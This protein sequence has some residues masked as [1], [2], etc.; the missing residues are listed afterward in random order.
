MRTS[1][2]KR[3]LALWVVCVATGVGAQGYPGGPVRLV[4]GLPG[5][6]V[7]AGARTLA[8][9]LSQRWHQPVIVEGKPGASEMLAADAVMRAPHDGQTLLIASEAAMVNNALVF[10]K[11]LVD[12]Q[13]DL[14]PVQA[15]FEVPF[16]LVVRRDLG[17]D[18]LPQFVALMKKEG[19]RHSY[20]S[21]G[22]GSPLQL[23][24]EGFAHEAGFTMLHV[25]YKTLGQLQQDLLGGSLDAAFLG[26]N[27]AMPFVRTGSLKLLA[28]T[29]TSRA[30]L[31]PEV[32]T[33]A[34]QGYPKVDYRTLIALLVPRG[35]PAPVLA[36]LGTDVNDV[37]R[38]EPFAQRFLA[39]QALAPDFTAGEALQALLAQRRASTQR[40]VETLHIQLD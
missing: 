1:W 19:R 39:P 26:V 14:V 21:S 10:R 15:L 5:G 18:T 23:A 34:E 12:A 31:A 29:G 28:V 9:L 32:P 3:A 25:P 13:H 35:T 30:R 40:L 7:D 33:F 8:D 16:A 11:P 24:M 37:L 36:R 17:V 22:I 2:L 27:S 38:S 6:L 4:H 20:A